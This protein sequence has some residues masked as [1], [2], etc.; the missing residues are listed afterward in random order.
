MVK[1]IDYNKGDD[2]QSHIWTWLGDFLEMII[3]SLIT[4]V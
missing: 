4:A 1:N 2:Y 3:I